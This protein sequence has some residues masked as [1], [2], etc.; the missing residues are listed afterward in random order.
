MK[1]SS[2][3]TPGPQDGAPG[4]QTLRSWGSVLPPSRKGNIIAGWPALKDRCMFLRSED[5]EMGLQTGQ[6]GRGQLS[7]LC[8]CLGCPPRLPEAPLQR[9]GR[10]PGLGGGRG[11]A[12][13]PVDWLSL[14][15]SC[16]PSQA[17]PCL[18]E[19]L[20]GLFLSWGAMDPPAGWQGT[21]EEGRSAQAAIWAPRDLTCLSVFLSAGGQPLQLG[22]PLQRLLHQRSP[23]PAL[24][25]RVCPRA[26][27]DQ[28]WLPQNRVPVL[29]P[30]VPAALPTP[31][32]LQ[33]DL[34]LLLQRLLPQLQPVHLAGGHPLLL[35]LQKK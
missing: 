17:A 1:P 11:G 27:Q 18:C 6:R 29:L 5:Q 34:P 7:R 28:P 24:Q 14:L 2:L 8:G 12:A 10:R 21:A 9:A 4:P 20:V 13:Q 32:E 19:S 31:H 22:Q 35:S 16:T 33:R 30:G 23:A 3:P 15:P 25:P 26:P